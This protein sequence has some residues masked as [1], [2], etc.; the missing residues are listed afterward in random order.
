MGAADLR[1]ASLVFVPSLPDAC[2][3]SAEAAL[4]VAQVAL[5]AIKV[6]LT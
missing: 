1:D 6:R 5:E 2:E 4:N 3:D